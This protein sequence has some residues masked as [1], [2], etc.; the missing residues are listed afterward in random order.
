M[1]HRRELDPSAAGGCMRLSRRRFITMLAAA[2]SAALI[3]VAEAAH[4]RDLSEIDPIRYLC[5]EVF[6][7]PAE[8]RA[9]RLV[10]RE[11]YRV[12]VCMANHRKPVAAASY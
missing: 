11:R 8:K 2:P 5:D 4:V 12:S 10:V 7:S 3:P 9:S 1:G 6:P